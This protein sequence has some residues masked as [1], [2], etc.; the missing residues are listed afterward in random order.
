MVTK[1][2]YLDV[3]ECIQDNSLLVNNLDAFQERDFQKI[4]NSILNLVLEKKHNLDYERL[5]KIICAY[6]QYSQEQFSNAT[7]EEICVMTCKRIVGFKSYP[8]DEYQ[9]IIQQFHETKSK[10]DSVM[11][12]LESRIGEINELINIDKENPQC[13]GMLIKKQNKLYSKNALNRSILKDLKKIEN[14]YNAL[15]DLIQENYIYKEMLKYAKEKIV[16][17]FSDSVLVKNEEETQ[18]LL[19]KMALEFSR[20]EENIKEF[21]NKFFDYNRCLAAWENA[22]N[23]IYKPFFM[24][25]MRKFS[26]DIET[27]YNQN[28]NGIYWNKTDELIEIC[29]EKSK[30][31]RDSDEWIILRNQNSEKYVEE[32]KKYVIQYQVVEYIKQKLTGLYCLQNRKDIMNIIMESFENKQYIIFVN[33]VV[34]QIEG[35]FFD[36]FVDANIQNRLDGQFDLFEKDDLKNKM[37]KNDTSMGIEEAALYFKFYFNSMIRNKVAH[38]RNHFK[39][40]EIEKVAHELLLDLQYVIHLLTKHSDTSEA[41]EYVQHTLQWLEI[42]F[43]EEKKGKCVFERLLNSLN[44]NVIKQRGNY[45]GFVDSH[46]ELY[47]IFNPYYEDA[48]EFAGVIDQRNKL[49]EYMVSEAFWNYVLQYVKEYNTQEIQHIKLKIDFKS[50]VKAI[51]M[52]IA[53]N[54]REVLPVISEVSKRLE[55]L[56]LDLR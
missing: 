52:Y 46:Q 15:F 26:D 20:E 18:N 49:R 56:Q 8:I 33:L 43:S 42:S 4:G 28:Y 30:E 2:M 24:I 1:E 32:L 9:Q 29:K 25:K 31:F 48:Y 45:F 41:I 35:I 51:Q 39:I 13:C 16:V 3:L 47:W 55:N 10:Y 11:L 7:Y 50:R 12:N 44:E 40:D 19:R 6:L 37:T 5:K 38:G 21:S 14:E 27:F 34:V 22:T 17:Y 36:M 54:K 23:S 53:K